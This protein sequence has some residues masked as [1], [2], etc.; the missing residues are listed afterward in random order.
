MSPD[1]LL[2]FY[3]SAGVVASA[4]SSIVQVIGK[5]SYHSLGASGNP[6][7]IANLYLFIIL[8]C[9]KLLQMLCK[10]QLC[11]PNPFLTMVAVAFH[12]FLFDF[13]SV[14]VIVKQTSM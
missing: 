1:K 6:F 8:T 13:F 3:L 4:G 5:Y 10:K 2:A 12:L 14:S 9:E 11:C 7:L